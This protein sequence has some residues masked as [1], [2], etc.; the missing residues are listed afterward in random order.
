MKTVA[1][2]PFAL[3][4]V[5]TP[6]SFGCAECKKVKEKWHFED[7]RNSET[8]LFLFVF[9][10]SEKVCLYIFGIV[11]EGKA[12]LIVDIDIWSHSADGKNNFL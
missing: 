6:L 3:R 5:K 9:F 1:Q 2:N 8:T 12:H 7:T 11:I 4:M 10:F